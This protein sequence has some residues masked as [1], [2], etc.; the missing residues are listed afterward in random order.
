[1]ENITNRFLKYISIDSKSDEKKAKI[2]KP[3]SKGKLS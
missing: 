2:I 1:M 3:T